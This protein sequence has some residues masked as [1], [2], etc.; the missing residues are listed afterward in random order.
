[1]M[2][3]DR[4]E[5]KA[6]VY[7][8]ASHQEALELLVSQMLLSSRALGDTAAVGDASYYGAG[9]VMW[10]QDDFYVKV[11]SL[12]VYDAV[13]NDVTALAL[14]LADRLKEFR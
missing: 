3:Q 11:W 9:M 6:E 5:F 1:L 4:R 14:G 8:V 12:D 2:L 10:V 7:R 13:R